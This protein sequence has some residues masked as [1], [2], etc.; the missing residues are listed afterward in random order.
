MNQLVNIIN[1]FIAL[2]LRSFPAFNSSLEAF[3]PSST[4]YWRYFLNVTLSTS[5]TR[6][7]NKCSFYCIVF[8]KTEECLNRPHITVNNIPL[9]EEQ[10]QHPGTCWRRLQ[11]GR[12]QPLRLGQ[13][14][15]QPL[16]GPQV[17]CILLGLAQRILWDLR[18][19]TTIYRFHR[20]SWNECNNNSF[21]TAL[22]ISH[23]WP[24]VRTIRPD[25]IL[26]ITTLTPATQHRTELT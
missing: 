25:L 10:L 4:L 21:W 3:C 15:G 6:C 16:G 26:P 12:N 18:G 14:L 19:N 5:V 17:L 1:I 20:K 13:L 2:L 9:Q 7:L 8:Y 11:P 22:L 23:L 24:F